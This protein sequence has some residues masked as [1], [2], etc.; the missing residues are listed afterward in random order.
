MKKVLILLLLSFGLIGS[1]YTTVCESDGADDI[2]SKDNKIVLEK[3]VPLAEQGNVDASYTIGLIYEAGG[4]GI[5][6]DIEASVDWYKKAAEQGSIPALRRLGR[7]Y[8]GI[9][10]YNNNIVNH[11]EAFTYYELAAEQGDA[12]A[13]YK[14]AWMYANGQGV[15]K[16]IEQAI[17][18][19]G[20]ASDQ[21]DADASYSIGLIYKDGYHGDSE[22]SLIPLK[23]TLIRKAFIWFTKAAE[24]G[25][26]RAQFEL[27]LISVG[28][29]NRA[30]LYRSDSGVCPTSEC[31]TSKG[32][33][34]GYVIIGQRCVE[35][36]W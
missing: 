33:K 15:A 23:H 7:Y 19:Y 24:Q 11:K 14:V 10:P 34:T 2:Y 17:N 4:K 26:I 5:L 25:N 22:A 27:S 32:R 3:L 16:D 9:F 28:E 1:A 35:K 21:G 20:K 8:F 18:W 6:K 13:Q 29:Y 12:R 30:L 36:F 31:I